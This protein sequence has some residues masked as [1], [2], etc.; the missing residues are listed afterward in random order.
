[1]TADAGTAPSVDISGNV[2]ISGIGSAE[3]PN[4]WRLVEPL[5]SSACKTA[6][7]KWDAGYIRGQLEAGVMQ[8]WL[9]TDGSVLAVCIT[10]IVQHPGKCCCRIRIMTGRERRRWQHLLEVIE[11]WAKAQGCDAMELI[12]RPGWSR[13]LKARNYEVTHLFCEK[14]LH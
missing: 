12:A 8:L 1:M 7:G 3:I 13:P 4:Y 5:I 9:I 11:C 14:E 10:E 2:R 6:R